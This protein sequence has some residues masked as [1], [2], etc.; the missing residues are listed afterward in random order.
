MGPYRIKEIVLTNAIELELSSSIKI[1]PIVN[2]SWV[3]LYKLQV[4]GQKKTLSKLVIIEEKKEFK[5]EKILNKRVVK[6]KKNFLVWL[7]W[8]TSTITKEY[9]FI[10]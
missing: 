2:I 3:Q 7:S 8:V 4:E 6:E 10:E 9:L 5:M 1:H